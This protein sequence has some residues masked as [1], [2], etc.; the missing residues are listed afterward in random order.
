MF[1]RPREGL[2]VNGKGKLPTLTPVEDG[3]FYYENPLAP[4]GGRIIDPDGNDV[5]PNDR[6]SLCRCGASASKPL[7]DGSH[8]RIGFSSKRLTDRGNDRRRSYEGQGVTIHDNRCVCSN[9][10]YCVDGLPDVFREDG[11]PWIDP[12]AAEP[13][14]II[15]VIKTCPSGALSYSVDGVEH[16]D[17]D[18]E[19]AIT[20][21]RNGP[22]MLTGWIEVLGEEPRAEDVS[23]EHCTCCRCGKSANKPFC[24]GSHAE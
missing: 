4:E 13:E 24:D 2:M 7:C 12:D 23:R 15:E 11:R 22:Y 20:I 18:R 17:L 9:A 14:K 3:P 10:H 8:A 21:D 19:P 1:P 16:R 5:T 6:V